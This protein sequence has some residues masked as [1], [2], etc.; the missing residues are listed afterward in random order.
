MAITEPT[1]E[2][3]A[4]I[5][6]KAFDSALRTAVERELRALLEA[7]LEEIIKSTASVMAHRLQTRIIQQQTDYL[8][9]AEFGLRVDGVAL[10]I[11]DMIAASTELN[12]G[13]T[14][15]HVRQP[16]KETTMK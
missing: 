5:A 15:E 8:T 3:A 14:P 11:S 4:T 7:K 2:Q 9:R 13:T 10:V 12:G 6:I 1:I 16:A